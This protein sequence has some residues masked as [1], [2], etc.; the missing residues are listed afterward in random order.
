MTEY[1]IVSLRDLLETDY[2]VN[3]ILSKFYCTYDEDVSVFL[4]EKAVVQEKRHISRTYLI[5]DNDGKMAA[6][7]T[8]AVSSI[9]ADNLQCPNNLKRKL[10][11]SKDNIIQSYLIGQI[12]RTEDS[13]KGLGK[14]V[15]KKAV[16]LILQINSAIGC[17]VIRIDCKDKEKLLD[18]YIGE[19]FQA[20]GKN[21]SNDLHQMIKIIS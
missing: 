21:R 3:E 2:D 8:I 14:W 12:G 1:N 7:C 19:G 16:D 20:V 5:F 18:Y 17:R 11:I 10:N 9:K 6:Y 4:K 13:Q 15:L